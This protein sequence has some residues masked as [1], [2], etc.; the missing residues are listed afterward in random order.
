MRL[1]TLLGV[2]AIAVL[3]PVLVFSII[4]VLLVLRLERQAAEQQIAE[5]AKRIALSVDREL[6]KAESSLRVLASSMALTAGNFDAFR[7]QAEAA[8]P[9]EGAW[10]RLFDP[11]GQQLV[12][13][14]APRETP[15]P[16]HVALERITETMRTQ[17]ASVSGLYTG[18]Y[19][20]RL[21]V[22]VD[23]PV[24]RNGESKYVLSMALLPETLARVLED[25]PIPADWIVAIFDRDG[26]T[27][28]RNVA[29]DRFVGQLGRPDL[30]AEV[31][32]KP[33]GAVQNVSREGIPLYNAFTRSELSGWSVVAGVPLSTLNIAAPVV[34]LTR[35]ARELSRG[36]APARYGASVTEVA[37]LGRAFADA[38]RLIRGA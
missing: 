15:L 26:R 27:I 9:S 31:H 17:R 21:I 2:L 10:I 11:G 20:R 3:L 28:V 16:V 37:E 32:A 38:A 25:R 13:T 8:I 18:R 30:V 35:S 7:G 34:D 36:A 29:A 4:A 33:E 23:V 12:N 22:S 6:A 19:S 14:G 1:R 5:T 24:V